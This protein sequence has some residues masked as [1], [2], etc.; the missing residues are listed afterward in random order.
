[1]LPRA[2][3]SFEEKLHLDAG[4]FDQVVVAQ[5]MRL[6]I[7]CASVQYRKMSAFHMG[8]EITLGALGNDG[9]LNTRFAERGE[10]LRQRQLFADTGPAHNLN[11]RLHT[12]E[13]RR[14][15]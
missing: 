15:W 4:D 6:I 3:L 12:R 14:R 8:N 1:M 9:N 5:R 13:R 10:A 2:A 7:Q 11:E